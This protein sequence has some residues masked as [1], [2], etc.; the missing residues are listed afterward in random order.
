MSGKIWAGLIA[1]LIIIVFGALI[2][3][4]A[5]VAMVTNNPF[6]FIE[7]MN[8]GFEFVVGVL[9]IVTGAGAMESSGRN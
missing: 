3:A 1:G 6:M 9:A 5:I 4:D 8:R 7:N 2:I